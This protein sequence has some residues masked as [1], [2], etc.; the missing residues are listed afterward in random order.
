MAL[1][2]AGVVGESK[3]D[4]MLKLRD[5]VG[6]EY[7]PSVVGKPDKSMDVEFFVVQMPVTVPTVCTMA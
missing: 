4:E 5:P 1:E 6:R 2:R 7:I 3:A